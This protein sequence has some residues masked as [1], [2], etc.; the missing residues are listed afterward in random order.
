MTILLKQPDMLRAD[1]NLVLN[2]TTSDIL[3]SPPKS[4]AKPRLQ[5]LVR[6]LPCRS[7]LWKIEK[8]QACMNAPDTIDPVTSAD[9]DGR[10]AKPCPRGRL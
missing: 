6:P 3:D 2:S 1:T 10:S 9:S 4:L 8:R 7:P 5:S